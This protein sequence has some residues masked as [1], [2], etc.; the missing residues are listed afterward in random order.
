M[1]SKSWNEGWLKYATGTTIRFLWFSP[2]YTARKPF[3]T[4]EN[5]EVALFEPD[6]DRRRICLARLPGKPIA[7]MFVFSSTKFLKS[8]VSDVN[9]RDSIVMV[10][11]NVQ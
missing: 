5:L 9:L 1:F 3:G 11:R 4:F 6:P 8:K 7:M 10:L 2:T